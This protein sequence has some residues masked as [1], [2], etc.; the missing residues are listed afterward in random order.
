MCKSVLFQR[1]L[2][3]RKVFK[4]KYKSQL[5]LRKILISWCGNFVERH[6]LRRV[7]G[8]SK[9]YGNCTF[10]QNIQIRKLAEILI[11]YTVHFSKSFF[12]H[13][14]KLKSLENPFPKEFFTKHGY[15]N[16]HF[17]LVKLGAG[18]F[19]TVAVVINCRWLISSQGNSCYNKSE[20]WLLQL[21]ATLIITSR[22]RVI[23]NWD[24]FI[25]NWGNYYKPVHN[26]CCW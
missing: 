23:I 12:S 22:D 2:Y 13:T 17:K 24:I 14:M 20:Q 15:C 8:D 25:T 21:R 4:Q 11:F 5:S 6:S 16:D 3:G 9:L 1:I 10:P 19:T 7:S 18:L 26:N